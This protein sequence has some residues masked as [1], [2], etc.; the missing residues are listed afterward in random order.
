MRTNA[1]F[2]VRAL[3]D[4]SLTISAAAILALTGSTLAQSPAPGVN[5]TTPGNLSANPNAA[6]KPDSPEADKSPWSFR[7]SGGGIYQFDTDLRGNPGSYSVA[8]AD[9]SFGLGYRLNDS[10]RLTLDIGNEVSWYEFDNATTVL[11]PSAKP[12][13]VMYQTDINP[14]V[15][16]DIDENWF[17]LAGGIFQFSGERKADFGKSFTAGAFGAVGYKISDDLTLYGGVLGKS[18]L[19][20]DALAVPIIGV[21]WR[22]TE[23]LRLDTRGLGAVL[24]MTVKPGLRVFV[25]ATYESREYRLS[26]ESFLREGVVRDRQIPVGIGAGIDLCKNFTLTVRGGVNVWQQFTVDT[27]NEVR[28]NRFRSDPTGFIGLRGEIRF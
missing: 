2:S 23:N 4:L 16:F 17:A 9:T 18:R 3:R 21:N 15:R 7:F 26:D 14:G 10:L 24:T 11:A 19:E 25:D 28:V 22:I 12:F 5:P 6:K 27:D 8:R 20:D 13:H 1:E